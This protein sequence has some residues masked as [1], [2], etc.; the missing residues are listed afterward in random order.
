MEEKNKD[1][2]YMV[3]SFLGV[4]L[5]G[6]PAM[7]SLQGVYIK[8]ISWIFSKGAINIVGLFAFPLIISFKLLID[9]Y[10]KR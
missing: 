3:W 1:R 4:L 6:I 8:G 9:K 7:L 10:G 5:I 2:L